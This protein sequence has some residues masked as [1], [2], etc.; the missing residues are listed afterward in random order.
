MRTSANPRLKAI[1]PKFVHFL[2][3]FTIL[4]KGL[5]KLEHPHGYEPVIMLFF[6]AAAAI[7]IVTLLHDRLHHHQR[8]VDAGVT[9][10]E[11][12]VM[13][14]V[15]F[16]SFREGARFLPYGFAFASLG[17]GVATMVRLVKA[18]RIQER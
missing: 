13:G 12:V 17:F 5:I 3:A 15:A 7:V 18:P 6:A 4:M 8:Y 16:L 2:T 10:V 14:L 11:C 1:L 9:A